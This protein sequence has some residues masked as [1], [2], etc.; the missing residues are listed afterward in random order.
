MAGTPIV[1][2]IFFCNLRLLTQKWQNYSKMKDDSGGSSLMYSANRGYLEVVKALL[3]KGADVNGKDMHGRTA[4]MRASESGHLEVVKVLLGKGA[5]V[6]AKDKYGA[7]ALKIASKAR[8]INVVN[9]LETQ[10]AKR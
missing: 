4:L 10:G 5:Y 2:N 8:Y 9:Y 6:N 3:D 7:T 1:F